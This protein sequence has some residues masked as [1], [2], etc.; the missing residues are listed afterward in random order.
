[1]GHVEGRVVGD[2]D[3][4]IAGATISTDNGI[5]TTTGSDGTYHLMLA[6]GEYQVTA[7]APGYRSSTLAVGVGGDVVVHNWHL[8]RE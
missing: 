2:V 6:P 4:P 7:S 3:A 5:S 1:M 8:H